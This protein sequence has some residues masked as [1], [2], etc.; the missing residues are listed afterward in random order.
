MVSGLGS[1]AGLCPR[2]ARTWMLRFINSGAAT[3]AVSY[4]VGAGGR[5]LRSLKPGG[6]ITIRLLPNV[7]RIH[8]PADRF[9]PRGQGRGLTGATSVPSTAPLNAS[10]YQ[11]TEPQTL[12][13]DAHLALTTIGGDS[14]QCVLVGS[15]VDA[16]TY[17]NSR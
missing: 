1:F 9:I 11:A 2:G 16:N 4:R 8:E 12:R 5:N 13:A 6:A 17:P 3:E 10:I 14:G 15:T 7:A